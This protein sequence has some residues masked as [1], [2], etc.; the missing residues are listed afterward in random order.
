MEFDSTIINFQRGERHTYAP[1]SYLTSI[2]R[3]RTILD[4]VIGRFLAG[5]E[6]PPSIANGRRLLAVGPFGPSG[7]GGRNNRILVDV[8]GATIVPSQ[9]SHPATGDD[10]GTIDARWGRGGD[11]EQ[12][13]EVAACCKEGR[14]HHVFFFLWVFL[15]ESRGQ[16]G[17]PSKL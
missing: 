16:G 17:S 15:S 10:G 6:L 5:P 7:L 1:K 3:E 14:A 2:A 9:R 11:E 12:Q 8:E 13:E 4:G